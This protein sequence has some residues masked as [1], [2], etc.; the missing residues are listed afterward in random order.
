MLSHGALLDVVH[1]VFVVT[2]AVTS[3]TTDAG[4]VQESIDTSRTDRAVVPACVTV[5][6]LVMPFP[7]TVILPVRFVGPVFA[8]TDI[9]SMPLPV[10]PFPPLA[11][12]TDS[13][14][15]A[16]LD[17]IHDIFDVIVAEDTSAAEDG[18]HAVGDKSSIG[19]GADVP[20]CVTVIVFVPALLETVIVPTR[21]APV[22]AVTDIMSMPLPVPPFPP[23]ATMTVSHSGA[24][25]DT[26]HDAFVVITADVTSA[27]ADG[28]HVV[29]NISISEAPPFPNTF[30]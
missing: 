13:H 28:F 30:K 27:A 11:T 22:F 18:F 3:A 29:G 16:L 23:L 9:M 15:G 2:Y 19:G 7:E 20:A 10:P 12:V 4:G 6:S 26:I 14:P 17:A 5:T 25:L 21:L 8:V 24:L 1:V